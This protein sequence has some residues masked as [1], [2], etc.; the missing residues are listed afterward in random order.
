M[1]IP[2]LFVLPSASEF[3]E[4]EALERLS[5]LGYPTYMGTE[6]AVLTDRIS[7]VIDMPDNHEHFVSA[8][9]K[10]AF[11]D[12]DGAGRAAEHL[13]NLLGRA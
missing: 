4:V 8:S 9:S 13:I 5:R 6:P 7:S 2:T 10:L 12:N 3:H 11:P 1:Q